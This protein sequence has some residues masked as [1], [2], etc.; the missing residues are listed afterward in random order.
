MN[1]ILF[2]LH[3]TTLLEQSIH[4]C[5]YSLIAQRNALM[6]RNASAGNAPIELT[7]KIECTHSSRATRSW[8]FCCVCNLNGNALKYETPFREKL[9]YVSYGSATLKWKPTHVDIFIQKAQTKSC[10]KAVLLLK[11][12]TPCLSSRSRFATSSSANC[13][14]GS[15]FASANSLYTSE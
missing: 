8:N 7:S 1:F 11:L 6:E 3:S 10:F 5:S 4:N 12:L 14:R 9:S 13:T 15:Y 2:W